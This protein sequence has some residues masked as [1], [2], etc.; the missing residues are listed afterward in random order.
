MKILHFVILCSLFVSCAVFKETSA[1][2]SE[3]QKFQSELNSEYRNPD[4][5][6]LRGK[7]F[8]NFTVH[9]FFKT[10]EKYRVNA[11]LVRTKN[12][13]PFEMP[14][15]SGKSK[16]YEEYGTLHFKIDGKPLSLKVY[17]SVTL[18]EQHGYEDYLFLPFRDLTANKETYGGGKY[19][20]LRIPKGETV[21]LDFN[22]SYHPYCAYN[23]FDYSCP[24]VPQD[25][26]LP[27]RIEAGVRYENK[28]FEH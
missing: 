16:N 7:N 3:I 5:T 20:D 8:E 18:R 6:P 9:P 26:W 25:N 22:K 15:S 1:Y 19:M 14:T 27:V 2:T 17:Q 4:E 10:N 13:V 21:V 28:Y 23:A 11:H 24:I 12:P